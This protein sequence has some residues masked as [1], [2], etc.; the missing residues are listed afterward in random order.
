MA[1]ERHASSSMASQNIDPDVESALARE[2][3]RKAPGLGKRTKGARWPRQD[4][5]QGS[6]SDSSDLLELTESE[7]EGQRPVKGGGAYSHTV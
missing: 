2:A 1:L 5:N 3:P 4:E 7:D 6:L